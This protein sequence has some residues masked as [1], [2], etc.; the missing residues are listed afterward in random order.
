MVVSL[1]L[2]IPWS[3]RLLI[4]L[5]AVDLVK[6]KLTQVAQ[7]TRLV[8]SEQGASITCGKRRFQR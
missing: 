2:W 1:H 4:L 7:W 3:Y 5:L 8:A 6:E